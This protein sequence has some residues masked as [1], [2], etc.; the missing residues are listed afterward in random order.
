[1]VKKRFDL[2]LGMNGGEILKSPRECI[3][4]P[5][6][7]DGKNTMN[8]RWNRRVYPE[9]TR[10]NDAEQKWEKIGVLRIYIL[11]L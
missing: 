10:K 7:G 3:R 2:G 8:N 1:L 4:R 11:V 9:K 6:I 5:G